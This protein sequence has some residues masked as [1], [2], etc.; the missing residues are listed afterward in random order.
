MATV[1]FTSGLRQLA[2]GT[3]EVHIKATNYRAAIRELRLQFPVLTDSVLEKFSVAIDGVMIHS[4]LLETFEPDSE[5]V[6]IPKI[7]GG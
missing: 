7:A 1:I 4:P 2:G 3:A 6:F 5:L